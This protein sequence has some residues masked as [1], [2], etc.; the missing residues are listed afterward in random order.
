MHMMDTSM[1]KHVFSYKN[2][3]SYS[4]SCYLYFF[5][6]DTYIRTCYGNYVD[7]CMHSHD[8]H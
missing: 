4:C 6:E 5:V 2:V 8:V 1:Y 3:H 7:N